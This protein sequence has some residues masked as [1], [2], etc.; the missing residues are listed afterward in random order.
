M[1]GWPATYMLQTGLLVKQPVEMRKSRISAGHDVIFIYLK[2]I[3]LA[4][5]LAPLSA[6]RAREDSSSLRGHFLAGF[7]APGTL[8]NTYLKRYGTMIRPPNSLS[9]L[10]TNA[11]A[12]LPFS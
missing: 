9:R 12:N 8:Y 7:V 4:H 11:P 5:F 3:L 6:S 10:S 2:R 1:G